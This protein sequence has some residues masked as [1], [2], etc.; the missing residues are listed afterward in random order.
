MNS[1]WWLDHTEP[2]AGWTGRSEGTAGATW[3]QF[4]WPS[5]GTTSTVSTS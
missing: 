5:D 3:D 2:R 4:D 1:S